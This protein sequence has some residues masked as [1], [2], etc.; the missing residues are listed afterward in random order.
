MGNQKRAVKLTTPIF[1]STTKYLHPKV[2]KEVF[3]CCCQWQKQTI[4]NESPLVGRWGKA[5]YPKCLIFGLNLTAS[6]SPKTARHRSHADADDFMQFPSIKKRPRPH[7]A[8]DEGGTQP[9][10]DFNQRP[11]CAAHAGGYGR[12]RARG[13]LR[14]PQGDRRPT[15]DFRKISGKHRQAARAE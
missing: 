15:G 9:D 5:P 3:G 1:Q 2:S 10:D 4:E 11:L 8:G 7:M 13:R 14:A 12:A 6:S